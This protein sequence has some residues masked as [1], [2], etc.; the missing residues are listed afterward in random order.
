LVDR[1]FSAN[2]RCVLE[3]P[4]YGRAVVGC[5]RCCSSRPCPE[6]SATPP[7]ERRRHRVRGRDYRR[8]LD[9]PGRLE[10]S[11]GPTIGVPDGAAVG[12]RPAR[13][14]RCGTTI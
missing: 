4:R 10:I 12:E 2:R 6:T 8:R 5:R 3:R 9:D 14:R 13:I 11:I 1:Q 7:C